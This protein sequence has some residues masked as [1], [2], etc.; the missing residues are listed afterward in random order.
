MRRTWSIF[1]LLGAGVFCA[2]AALVVVQAPTIALFQVAL[3]VTEFGHWLFAIPLVL[4]FLPAPRTPMNHAG[5]ALALVASMLLFSTVIRAN[6]VARNLPQQLE[7]AFPK[8]AT[9]ATG[10]DGESSTPLSW[11]KLWFGQSVPPVAIEKY[12]F[13]Q[14]G[15]EALR[16]L[17]YPHREG[18]PAP[19][20]IAIH[21]AQVD[22]RFRHGRRHA[23]PLSGGTWIY[24]RLDRVP[25]CPA[26][27]M[28][29]SARRCAR[30]HRLFA[31]ARRGS[32][33]R[34]TAL[35]VAG[36]LRRRADR[37]GG[38]LRGAPSGHPRLHCVLFAGGHALR[39]RIRAHG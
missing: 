5:T 9:A 27:D 4:A 36:T 15:D 25:V 12:V 2:A 20:V 21:G 26:L 13:A 17:F 23:Q 37:R 30:R 14:H 28:A 38:R 32:R 29:G 34:S 3:V 1:R 31:K 11:K 39:L 18:R 24:G 22:Q 33:D 10:G 6:A 16:L 19:C 7:R 35:C 8:L